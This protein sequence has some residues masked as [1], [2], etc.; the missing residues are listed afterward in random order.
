M[1]R[2]QGQ[3]PPNASFVCKASYHITNDNHSIVD[4]LSALPP[5]KYNFAPDLLCLAEGCEVRLLKNINVRAGLVN[6]ASGYLVQ[7]IYNNSDVQFLLRGLNPPPHCLL[8]DFPSF[9]GF[10]TSNGL[11]FPI[12][13]HPHLVPIFREKFHSFDQELPS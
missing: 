12:S 6:S 3:S 1:G 4:G 2:L 10:Q 13:D 8:I 5:G 11:V 9:R 7:V